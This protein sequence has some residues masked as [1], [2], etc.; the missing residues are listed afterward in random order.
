MNTSKDSWENRAKKLD[1]RPSPVYQDRIP[2]QLWELGRVFFPIPSGKK[3]YSYPHG[4]EKYRYEYNSETLNAYFEA[5]WK[6]YGI[7]CA[8]SL[9]VV[10][11]DDLEYISEVECLP[12]TV[13]QVTGSREG[14]HL[15]FF[16]EGMDRRIILRDGDKH[17]GEIKCDENGYVLGPGSLHPSGNTYGPLEGGSIARVEKSE[18]LYQLNNILPDSD[19]RS[20]GDIDDKKIEVAKAAR[21][22]SKGSMHGL[23]S[24]KADDVLPGLSEGERV[25]HPVHGSSTGSNFMKNEGSRTFTCWRCQCGTG[26]GCVIAPVQYLAIE[27]LGSVSDTVCEDVKRSWSLDSKLHFYAW[28]NAVDSGLLPPE[29]PPSRVIKGFGVEI[30]VIDPGE[31]ISYEMYNTLRNAVCWEFSDGKNHQHDG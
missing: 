29:D 18:L 10:D 8:G 12:D 31:D 9:A 27:E 1:H 23:Y 13:S 28:K 26:D 3:G 22:N 15:F 14:V 17:I 7:S 25:S 19:N 16:V 11:I 21:D 4:S 5:G 6:N 24:L 20:G 30:G 2:E